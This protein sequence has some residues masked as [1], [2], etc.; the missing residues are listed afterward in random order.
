[1]ITCIDMEA[2]AAVLG[3]VLLE[4]VLFKNLEI[5][6]RHFCHNHHRTIFRAMKQ[7]SNQREFINLLVVTIH[8]GD[9]IEQI[10]GT[11]YLLKLTESVLRITDIIHNER[12]ILEAYHMRKSWKMAMKYCE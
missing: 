11:S 6:E 10:G 12:L 4:G 8:L 3:T 5:D 1:M 2:E 9:A 7:A